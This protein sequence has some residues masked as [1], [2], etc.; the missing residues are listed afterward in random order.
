MTASMQSEP[1]KT[2]LHG[3]CS[4]FFTFTKFTVYT[5]S[6]DSAA[7][8]RA[9]TAACVGGNDVLQAHVDGGLA[10][11]GKKRSGDKGERNSSTVAAKKKAAAP[12][13]DGANL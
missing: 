8:A 3:A 13:H 5:N 6:V 2:E 11:V 12:T 9:A 10:A 1:G 4:S 7:P